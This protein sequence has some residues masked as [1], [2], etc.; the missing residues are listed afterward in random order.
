MTEIKPAKN[1]DKDGFYIAKAP[2]FRKKHPYPTNPLDEPCARCIRET[3]NLPN[4][5]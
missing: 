4:K 5:K 1:P 2:C 3:H